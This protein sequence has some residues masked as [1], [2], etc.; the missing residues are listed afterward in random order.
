[1]TIPPAGRS[2]RDRFLLIVLVAAVLPLSGIGLWLTRAAVRAGED[3]RREQ[4]QDALQQL[5]Q[6]VNERWAFRQADLLWLAENEFVRQEL[7]AAPAASDVP[8]DL[9][10]LFDDVRS[11]VVSLRYSDLHDRLRW[12]LLRADPFDSRLAD[13]QVDIGRSRRSAG[14]APAPS[15][16]VRLDIADYVSGR[17]IGTL[18]AQVRFSSILPADTLPAGR[19]I[20]LA[21]LD[22][23]G[24]ALIA[25]RALPTARFDLKSFTVDDEQWLAETRTMETLPLRLAAAAPLEPFVAPFKRAAQTGAVALLLVCAA[26]IMMTVVLTTRLTR[27]LRGL[28]TAADAVAA[29]DLGMR[30]HVESDDEIGR[31]AVAFNAMTDSLSRTLEQLAQQQALAAVGRFAASLSHEIRNAHT[32]IR[33]D[34]QRARRKLPDDQPAGQLVDRALGQIE[35]LDRTV[36]GSLRVARGGTTARVSGDVAEPLRLAIDAARPQADARGVTIEARL[37]G[38]AAPIQADPGALQHLFFN[39]LLNAVEASNAGSS[40]QVE[41]ESDPDAAAVAVLIR[42]SGDG[43]AA[44][45]PDR[46]FEP[47]YTTKATG[48]GLGLA[49]ARSIAEAHGGQIELRRSEDG[50]VVAHVSLP[51]TQFAPEESPSLKAVAGFERRP[52]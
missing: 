37:P 48:T 13:E 45:D 31:V 16:A 11:D 26:A 27:S 46:L 20:A 18:E 3:L 15:F 42:N 9:T 29:G 44:I 10:A 17:R 40:V 43:L 2:L 22:T 34:L 1:M 51:V 41:V 30:V 4:L 39:L 52:T 12:E 35:R 25:S 32:S 50:V 23:L 24:T 47:F 36:T 38:D 14:P 5:E 33:L 19:G 8:D 28:A 6:T 7:L 21:V 49:I